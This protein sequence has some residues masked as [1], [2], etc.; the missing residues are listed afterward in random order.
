MSVKADMMF[1]EGGGTLF[2]KGSNGGYT[3]DGTTLT[4]VTDADY[5]DPT[6]PGLGY[7][8]GRFY[9]MNTNGDIYNS[10]EDA[11]SSWGALNF[12]NAQFEPDAGVAIARAGE[13][14][15]ALGVYTTELF[16]DAKNLTNSP[17]SAVEN[18][19][20]LTGCADGNTGG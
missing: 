8:N 2:I 19:V 12:V 16:W 10:D 9:V 5:P 18:G 14:I 15:V 17:L 7:L 11:P 3:Y 6:V 1:I 20:R 13:Y 4:K